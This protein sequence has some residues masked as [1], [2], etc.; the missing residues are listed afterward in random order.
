MTQI[1]ITK[2]SVAYAGMTTQA[3]HERHIFKVFHMQTFIYIQN[4]L[5]VFVSWSNA[6][7]CDD[8]VMT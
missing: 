2:I 6:I 5:C 1:H 8:S 4:N 7:R 3:N